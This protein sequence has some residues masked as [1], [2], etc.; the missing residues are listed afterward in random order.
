MFFDINT[1]IFQVLPYHENFWIK[2][3]LFLGPILLAFTQLEMV[4]LLYSLVSPSSLAKHFPGGRSRLSRK[5]I[6]LRVR[7]FITRQRNGYPNFGYCYIT[8]IF[9]ECLDP[10]R[11]I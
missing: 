4:K 11:A 9:N 5:C 2:Q 7:E 10:R 3:G 1:S 6:F 8:G